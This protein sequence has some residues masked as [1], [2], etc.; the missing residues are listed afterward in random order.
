MAREPARWAPVG[1][2]ARIIGVS[3]SY[4]RALVDLRRLPAKRVTFG[5]RLI[6]KEAV[7]KFAQERAQRQAGRTQ[8]E[9]VA[10]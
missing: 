10:P 4:V 6:D 8:P 1:E 2:A 5:I 9:V 7:D 3:R